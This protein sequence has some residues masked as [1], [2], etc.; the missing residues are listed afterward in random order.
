MLCHEDLPAQL[1]EGLHAYAEEQVDMERWICMS[2]TMKWECAQ[3]L[4]RPILLA[5]FGDASAVSTQEV[6]AGAPDI[7]ELDLDEEQAGNAGDSDFK[8]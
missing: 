6:L 5:A 1:V 7:I 3:E 8:E 2:W 4:A